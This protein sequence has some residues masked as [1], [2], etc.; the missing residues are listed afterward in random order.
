MSHADNDF[1]DA[2]QLSFLGEL[3]KRPAGTTEV[4]RD[5]KDD[6][7]VA[8]VIREEFNRRMAMPGKASMMHVLTV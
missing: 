1:S 2:W 5:G 8:R 4:R 3:L 6:A 7:A